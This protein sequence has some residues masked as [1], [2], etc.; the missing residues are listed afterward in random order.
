MKAEWWWVY[1]VKLQYHTDV[2]VVAVIDLGYQ[3]VLT[4]LSS[5]FFLSS[6]GLF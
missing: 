4:F 3:N 5:F 2:T 6:S 1:L